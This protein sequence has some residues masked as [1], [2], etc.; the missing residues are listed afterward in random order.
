MQSRGFVGWHPEL[1]RHQE[2]QLPGHA[3]SNRR[4]EPERAEA[5]FTAQMGPLADKPYDFSAPDHLGGASGDRRMV[6]SHRIGPVVSMLIADSWLLGG[7]E[8]WLPC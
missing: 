8:S 1:A 3:E 4:Q 5:S 6:H 2:F 7:G